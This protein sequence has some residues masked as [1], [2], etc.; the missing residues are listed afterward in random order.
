MHESPPAAAAAP[1]LSRESFRGRD[2][3]WF[4]DNAAAVSTLIRG[5][6]RPEDIDHIAAAV[7]FQNASLNHRAWYE[8][9]DSESNPADGLSRDGLQDAWTRK[10]N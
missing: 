10:Q 5:S 2:F 3:I 7:A 1:W 8:W 4:V 9:I 6:A